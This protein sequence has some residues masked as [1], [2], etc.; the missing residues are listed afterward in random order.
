ML[1]DIVVLFFFS[2]HWNCRRLLVQIRIKNDLTS[3]VKLLQK[4]LQCETLLSFDGTQLRPETVMTQ[5]RIL[6]QL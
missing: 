6:P 4:L 1:V 3:S 2:V 5:L